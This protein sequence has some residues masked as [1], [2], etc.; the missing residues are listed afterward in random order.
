MLDKFYS[1]VLLGLLVLA[2]LA[3]FGKADLGRVQQGVAS[4]YSDSFH[5]RRTASGERYDRTAL[6]AAHKTLPLGTEV[7]VT[8]VKTGDSVVVRINDRGP[9]IKGRIID[10]SRRA[11]RELGMVNKGVDKVR[12]EVISRPEDDGA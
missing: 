1:V 10:L 6:T 9:F 4:L 5:G 12:V 7:R 3:A 2:P 8:R 11:A